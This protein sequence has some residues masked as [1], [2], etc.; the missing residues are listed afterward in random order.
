MVDAHTPVL[1][2][3]SVWVGVDDDGTTTDETQALVAIAVVV[4]HDLEAREVNLRRFEERIA[5]GA[6]FRVAIG[7]R[8][9]LLATPDTFTIGIQAAGIIATGRALTNLVVRFT[10][11]A[12]RR[13]EA[14]RGATERVDLVS[15]H[16]A[17]GLGDFD[18]QRKEV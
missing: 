6:A 15:V 17:W 13:W 18:F 7:F 10:W 3:I 4:V 8:A 1:G 14:L 12:H 16:L 5:F 2:N 9:T 11:S